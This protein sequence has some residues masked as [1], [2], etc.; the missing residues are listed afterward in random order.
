MFDIY[1]AKKP[2]PPKPSKPKSAGL[3]E[4][5]KPGQKPT[6][7]PEGPSFPIKKKKP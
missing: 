4:K 1:A 2:P 6:W 3:E 7:G 5:W